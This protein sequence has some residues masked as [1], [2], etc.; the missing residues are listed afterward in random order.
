MIPHG[1]LEERH[2]HQAVALGHPH[3]LAEVADGGGG[4]A[5]PPQAGER[6]HARVVPPVHVPFLHERRRRRLERSV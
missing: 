5:P 6:G 3:A 4:N 1:V 2:L